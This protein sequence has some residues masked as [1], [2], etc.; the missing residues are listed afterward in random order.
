[1]CGGSCCTISVFYQK[2]HAVATVRHD[3]GLLFCLP[4]LLCQFEGV[5]IFKASFHRSTSMKAC[6][7]T[8]QRGGT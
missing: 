5:L 3:R 6:S 4:T 7:R 8:A 1:M 2:E